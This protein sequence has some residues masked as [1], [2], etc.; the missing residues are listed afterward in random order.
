MAPT[1]PA[2]RTIGLALVAAAF[3]FSVLV[4]ANT[5]DS[6]GELSAAQIEDGL[7]VRATLQSG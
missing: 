6:V 1:L 3:F 2:T 5:D 4:A 7:Q